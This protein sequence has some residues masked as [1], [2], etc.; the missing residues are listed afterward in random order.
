MPKNTKNEE[1]E[2]RDQ[3][4]YVYCLTHTCKKVRSTYV[5]YT[6]D[7]D[8]RLRVHNQ[9]LAARCWTTSKNHYK[10]GQWERGY[11]VSGLASKRHARQLE[12]L[13]HRKTWK[14]AKKRDWETEVGRRTRM[15]HDALAIRER[16]TQKAPLTKNVPLEI[17]WYA[18][19]PPA[20]YLWPD[21]IQQ[22]RLM[23]QAETMRR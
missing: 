17:S 19:E 15:L 5:G 23:F 8:H 1:Q 16:V 2:E 9:E 3:K 22:N 11:V 13:L 18:I 21:T 12:W 4:W 6:Y 7:V 14:I 10:Q 20:L